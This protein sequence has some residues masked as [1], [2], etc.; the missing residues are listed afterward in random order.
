M[1]IPSTNNIWILS[2]VGGIILILYSY[3]EQQEYVKLISNSMT[4]IDV[5]LFEM[6]ENVN[7]ITRL[8]EK[9]EKENI[10]LD[11]RIENTNSSLPQ[12]C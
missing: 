1:T 9:V 3:S 10:R 12:D 2:L 4:K 8:H 5:V 11:K 7:S 6:T